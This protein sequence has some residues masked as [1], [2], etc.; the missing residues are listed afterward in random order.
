MPVFM[1]LHV[2]AY[3]VVGRG[4]I[5]VLSRIPAPKPGPAEDVLPAFYVHPPEGQR[6]SRIARLADGYGLALLLAFTVVWKG[7]YLDA[8]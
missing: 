7:L 8:K 6:E 5:A 2:T 3:L 4:E 1:Y